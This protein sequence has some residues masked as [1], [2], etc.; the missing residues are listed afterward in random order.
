MPLLL[1]DS[2]HIKKMAGKAALGCQE[3]GWFPWV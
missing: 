2:I 1:Y 3:S